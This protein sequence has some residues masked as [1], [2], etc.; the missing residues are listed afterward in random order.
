MRVL[1]ERTTA[2]LR[3]SIGAGK[4]VIKSLSSPFPIHSICSWRSF[5]K[6]RPHWWYLYPDYLKRGNFQTV[7]LMSWHVFVHAGGCR[8]PGAA[9]SC[10][11]HRCDLLVAVLLLET[12]PEETIIMFLL[13]CS[14]LVPSLFM[15][16]F[17]YTASTKWLGKHTIIQMRL[18]LTAYCCLF[19][20]QAC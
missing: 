7:L 5:V 16:S 10:L 1:W 3:T 4:G 18:M 15:C 14:Q 8:C 11:D 20:D 13:L 6:F 19:L 17:L 12:N 9:I 2:R